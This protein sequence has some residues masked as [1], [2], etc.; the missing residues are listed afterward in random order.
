MRRIHIV[1]LSLLALSVLFYLL[2]YIPGRASQ[3]YGPPGGGLT[4]SQ[5]VEYAARLL[6][7]AELLTTPRDPNGMEQDFHIDEGESVASISVRLEGAGLVSS[8]QAFY[9]YV[10]YTGFDMTIQA[11]DYS[12]SPA[13]SIV[14]LARELQDATPE[15]VTF[16]I[17][18]GWRMEEIAASLPTSGLSM[19]YDEFITAAQNPP[20][21]LDFLPPSASMEGFFYPDSYILPRVTTAEQLME[22]LARA[23]AL[24]LTSEL[25]QGFAQQ[26]LEVY[27]AVTLASL[28]QREGVQEEEHALI[29]SVF[30]NRLNAGMHLGSDPTVQ[31]AL[32][33]NP[34]QATWWTNPLDAAD[35]EIDTPYNTYKYLG[36]PPG[37][38]ASPGESALR[39][40]AFPESSPY[41]Y[42][43]ARC[44]GSGYHSFAVT[45]EEHIQNECP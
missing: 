25:R 18:P 12:L 36:L 10:V 14:D 33:F 40:V 24:H 26:G 41:Y 38:I 27:Q 16:V 19:T 35:L 3:L 43:R 34:V 45:L 21:V 11:G 23:F 7:R 22:I 44:D 5:R 31:Y 42:F 29:A 1:I 39:A 2:V 20:P 17:L 9:D 6:W 13:L 28:V 37:P 4:L 30:I 8:A 15:E 32:G